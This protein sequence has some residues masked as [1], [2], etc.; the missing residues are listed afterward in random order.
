[1]RRL[2]RRRKIVADA[3][4]TLIELLV[5]LVII[6]LLA[7]VATPP[8]IRYL[9]KAK[10]DTA[11]IQIQALSAAVDMFRLDN[12][13]YPSTE[14]GLQALVVR[15]SS[16]ERWNGPYVKKDSS[17]L[18]PWGQR[19]QYRSPGEHGD[20]DLFTLG[21]DKTQGGTGENADVGNWQ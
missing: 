9:G 6:G 1:M 18:D 12:D 7:S 2:K 11:K 8:V 13:R 20:Y 3:G 15:P 10:T 21:A 5:V 19:Y 4:F 16:A 17:L 14:E